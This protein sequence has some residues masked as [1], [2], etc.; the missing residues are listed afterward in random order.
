MTFYGFGA[1]L[2][3]YTFVTLITAS[4]DGKERLHND[5]N[6]FNVQDIV[7]EY[8]L[9]HERWV[10][11][12]NY[13]PEKHVIQETCLY[14]TTDKVVG[15]K[16]NFTMHYVNNSVSGTEHKYGT[17]FKTSNCSDDGQKRVEYNAIRVSKVPGEAGDKE[18]QQLYSDY[19]TCSFYLSLHEKPDPPTTR[20]PCLVFITPKANGTM[21]ESCLKVY[22][23]MCGT[24][25]EL[26][27]VFNSTCK[28]YNPP[29][30]TNKQEERLEQLLPFDQARLMYQA[31]AS[32]KGYESWTE[33]SSP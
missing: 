18:Y 13:K 25:Q 30:S 24:K 17:F 26:K 22:Q 31:V 12:L 19:E 2:L 7:K 16:V 15:N 5:Q 1:V 11:G 27:V 28:D 21:P 14:F 4:S 29:P 10:Y 6:Y 32:G 33:D 20:L 8:N 3:T 9:T 23:D